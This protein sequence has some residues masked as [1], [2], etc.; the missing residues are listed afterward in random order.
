[1]NTDQLRD[2]FPDEI[3]CRTFSKLLFGE[4]I[5]YVPI[6]KTKSHINCP[7]LL[8]RPVYMSAV[9]VKDNLPLPL[10]HRCIVANCLYGNGFKRCTI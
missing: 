4:I 3:A 1:M 10:R 8:V 2:S 9:N 5:V 7:A 6:A